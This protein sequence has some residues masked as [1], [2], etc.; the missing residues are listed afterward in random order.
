MILQSLYAKRTQSDQLT[1]RGKKALDDLI[2]LLEDQENKDLIDQ[3]DIGALLNEQT[4]TDMNITRGSS[5]LKKKSNKFPSPSL[6]P[7]LGAFL[8]MT[9]QEIR[10]LKL[11]VPS[12]DTLSQMEEEALKTLTNQHQ[13][14]I[15]PSD[16]GGNI[17]VMNNSQYKTMCM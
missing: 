16:N 7:N 13:L 15:K 10:R 12:Q 9:T 4:K 8:A 11:K 17:V 6:N 14:T 1:A 5:A 2:S 3:V